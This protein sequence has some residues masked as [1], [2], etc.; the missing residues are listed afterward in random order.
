MTRSCAATSG[1]TPCAN[2]GAYTVSATP[3]ANIQVMPARIRS[4]FTAADVCD[5]K[6]RYGCR[7]SRPDAQ[8]DVERDR[9]ALARAVERVDVVIEPRREKQHQPRLGR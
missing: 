6:A 4:P 3:N 5:D 9:D 8:G 1:G 7:S 2:P